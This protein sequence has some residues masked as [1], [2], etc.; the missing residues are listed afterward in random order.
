[1]EKTDSLR[2]RLYSLGLNSSSL[3][4]DNNNGIHSTPY[5]EDLADGEQELPL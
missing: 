1:M 2:Q 3:N 5:K 4:S